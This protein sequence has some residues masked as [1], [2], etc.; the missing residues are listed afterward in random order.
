MGLYRCYFMNEA[1]NTTAWQALHCNSC[2]EAESFARELLVGRVQDSAV[3]LW[4]L[5]R[6]VY[7]H[8]PLQ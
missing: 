4:N 7:R 6:C 8:P 2:E 3:E 5:D 1:G